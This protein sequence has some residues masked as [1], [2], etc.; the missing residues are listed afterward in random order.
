MANNGSTTMDVSEEAVGSCAKYG[1]TDGKGQG[2][3]GK[4]GEGGGDKEPSN[5]DLFAKISEVFGAVGLVQGQV[6]GVSGQLNTLQA[7][8]EQHKVETALN[9]DNVRK[10]I[11]EIESKQCIL[12]SQQQDQDKEIKDLRANPIQVQ[13]PVSGGAASGSGGGGDGQGGPAGPSNNSS[14]SFVPIGKR[15]VL[16][17]GGFEMDTERDDIVK[18]LQGVFKDCIGDI[19][20]D[21]IFTLRKRANSGKAE[22]KS[23]SLMWQFLKK[24]KGTKFEH[25]GNRIYISIDKMPREIALSTKVGRAV[26]AL[27]THFSEN[28]IPDAEEVKKHVDAEW[29][30]GI[31]YCRA[32]PA[33]R[34]ARVYEKPRG[35]ENLIVGPAVVPFGFNS[36]EHLDTINA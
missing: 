26:K 13:V 11:K 15:K 32:N 1:R 5:S 6:G 21:G 10:Q 28:G 35:E 31:V 9:F 4:T 12:K 34:W 20:K 18:F 24:A 14:T 25:E 23:S 7:G 27:K 22:F 33:D 36:A 19:V 3:K 30:L 8:F 17:C 2:E 29:N 16:F